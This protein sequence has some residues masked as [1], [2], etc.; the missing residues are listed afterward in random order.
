[1]AKSLA[2][3]CDE[4]ESNDTLPGVKR[5]VRQEDE[6]AARRTTRAAAR[7]AKA[8]ASPADTG[9][10]AAVPETADAPDVPADP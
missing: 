10:T 2:A 3:A 6:A 8:K 4:F 9:E 1:M 5:A 7:S